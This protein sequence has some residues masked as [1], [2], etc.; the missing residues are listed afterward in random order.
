MR[1]HLWSNGSLFMSFIWPFILFSHLP[2]VC[3]CFFAGSFSFMS[4]I[5]ACWTGLKI[6][7]GI[8]AQESLFI[9]GEMC[10]GEGPGGDKSPGL[11]GIA[12][13]C[14]ANKY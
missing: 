1:N 13:L 9:R 10:A 14:R 2:S 11:W 8:L 4:G 7:N 6:R 12:R 3:V 5:S